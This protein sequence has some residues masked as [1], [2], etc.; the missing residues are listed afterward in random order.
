L[1][2]LDIFFT[3]KTFFMKKIILFLSIL[4]VSVLVYG[5]AYE[6]TVQYQKGLQPA[7]VI[8]LPYPPSVV[9]AAMDDYL[10]KKG[11]SRA[12]DIKGFSTFRNTQPLQNDS[13]NADLYF[14]TERKSRKE[15]EVTVV[16]LLVLPNAQQTSA[17]DLHYLD[18][19]D[20]KDYLNGLATAIEAYNL[21]LTIKDQNDAVIK[22]E[23]KY[24]NLTN[25]GED[26]ENKRTAI[27][28]KIADNKNDQQQQLKD[29]EN[30]KQKLTQW[31]SQRKS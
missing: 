10:S 8:E 11:K 30:Q 21:E 14:K 16:S 18:M 20:A 28:K 29:I 27:E 23:A 24:K 31:V 15:K 2:S 4:L 17:G 7:A 3:L 26:L 19:N 5:Q 13:I 6:G 12:N 25:E 9:N 22:A 1:L